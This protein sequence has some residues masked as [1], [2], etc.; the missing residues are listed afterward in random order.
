MQRLILQARIYGPITRQ[1]F[2]SAGITRGMK[3]LDLGSGAG[4]VALLLADLVG[5]EGRVVGVD[6]N[7]AI[8]ESA[9]RRVDA[10][11]WSNIELLAG[12]VRH[13]TLPADFDAVVGRW[14]LMHVDDPADVVRHALAHLRVGGIV[15]FLESEDLTRAVR[16]FP[17]TPL[18]GELMRWMTPPPGSLGP[19]A[20][21]GMRL[22]S[23]FLAAGLPMPQLRLDAPVGGGEDWPGFTYLAESLRILLPRLEQVGAVSASDVDIDTLAARLRDEA[24][25][26]SAIQVLPAVIGAWAR[27]R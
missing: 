10:A 17:P 16:T 11:G 13:L 24:L 4:D 1:L 7:P 23:A 3:V 22:P 9:R 19:T 27:R 8:V 21:M 6:I 2:V 5:A 14:I 12:D 18:H 25:D 20:D 26:R 15:A